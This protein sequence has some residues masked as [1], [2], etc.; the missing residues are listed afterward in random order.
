MER[1]EGEPLAQKPGRML[2]FRAPKPLPARHFYF[3]ENA[4]FPIW[5]DRRK[6]SS[7]FLC[8]FSATLFVT[9]AIYAAGWL[10]WRP[11]L[12]DAH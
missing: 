2:P 1:S 6:R 3:A 8:S 4:T 5:I 7:F 12:S 10:I 11:T 9:A